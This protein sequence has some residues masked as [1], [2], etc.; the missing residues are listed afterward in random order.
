VRL[1]ERRLQI[2]DIL[3]H[4]L[5]NLELRQLPFP[6]HVGHQGSQ[7]RQVSGY[8]FCFQVT[9]GSVDPEA[10]VQD[11]ST[12][13]HSAAHRA[14][15]HRLHVVRVCT[16]FPLWNCR[17]DAWLSPSPSSHPGHTGLFERKC[18]R[19]EADRSRGCLTTMGDQRR[20]AAARLRAAAGGG[21]RETRPLL[22]VRRRQPLAITAT[23]TTVSEKLKILQMVDK[24]IYVWRKDGI[25]AGSSAKLEILRPVRCLTRKMRRTASGV[26]TLWPLSK[27][28]RIGG[29]NLVKRDL[30]SDRVVVW[31]DRG[32]RAV[33]ANEDKLLVVRATEEMSFGRKVERSG[34]GA[35]KN[36][37]N[38]PGYRFET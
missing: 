14:H 36:P 17:C 13:R 15:H 21:G 20:V 37:A 29:A 18:V 27:V 19:L 22:N 16:R 12:R 34:A 31:N 28:G 9:T 35:G 38:D 30:V 7:L 6:R 3:D 11:T 33:D 1:L 32:M 23:T 5:D 2:A 26:Q 24:V 10:V 25:L 8:L 4:P